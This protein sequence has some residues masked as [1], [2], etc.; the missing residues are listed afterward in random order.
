MTVPATATLP[1][2]A[3][4]A[5]GIVQTAFGVV[6]VLLAAFAV[7]TLAALLVHALRRARRPPAANGGP[8]PG[9]SSEMARHPRRLGGAR[10]PARRPAAAHRAV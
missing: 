4:P 3:L 1:P 9:R 10:V 2:P 8:A 6:H 7:L 5:D